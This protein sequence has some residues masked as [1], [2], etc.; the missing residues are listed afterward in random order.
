MEL[1]EFSKFLFRG[2]FKITVEETRKDNLTRIDSID[3]KFKNVCSRGAILFFNDNQTPL[4]KHLYKI[5]LKFRCGF[6]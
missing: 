2:N 5:I 3:C 6:F 1:S 4:S